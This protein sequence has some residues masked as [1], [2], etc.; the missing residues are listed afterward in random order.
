MD[1]Y[2]EILETSRYED[3][4]QLVKTIVVEFRAELLV[5]IGLLV[6][7]G[8]VIC[9]NGIKSGMVSNILYGSLYILAAISL[10]ARIYVWRSAQAHKDAQ[11]IIKKLIYEFRGELS[12]AIYL[13]FLTGTN[14]FFG[15][16]F[17]LGTLFIL[18]SLLVARRVYFWK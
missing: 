12:A 14:F 4:L 3:A 5:L 18:L 10:V 17:F 1:D 13:L 9:I 15:R 8:L 16:H 2:E 7:A 6:T 11:R